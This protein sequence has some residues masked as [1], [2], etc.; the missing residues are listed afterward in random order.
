MPRFSV[1]VFPGVRVYGGHS[2][3]PREPINYATKSRSAML[4]ATLLVGALGIWL[5]AALFNQPNGS[6]SG[7]S[8]LV[9]FA[10]VIGW[11]W[12]RW[13]TANRTVKAANPPEPRR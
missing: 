7:W 3:K 2:R 6:A 5:S 9:A 13:D 12:I 11:Q 4:V 10:A 1:K 8:A